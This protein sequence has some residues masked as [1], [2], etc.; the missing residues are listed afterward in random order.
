MS[1]TEVPFGGNEGLDRVPGP[2]VDDKPL[3]IMCHFVFFVQ[4]LFNF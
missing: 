1:V 2:E 4:S 3:L